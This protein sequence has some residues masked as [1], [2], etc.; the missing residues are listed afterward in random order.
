MNLRKITKIFKKDALDLLRSK[1]R[2]LAL[3]LFPM[4]M[5]F[6]FGFGFGGQISGVGVVVTAEKKTPSAN[7]VQQAMVSS[8]DKSDF[9]Q[10][11]TKNITKQ[12][13][14]HLVEEG[15]YD[16]MIYIPSD[17]SL[18]ASAPP[19]KIQVFV[20]PANSPQLRS[21]VMEGIKKVVGN[22]RGETS[23]VEE[24]GFYSNLEYM[25][26]L[27]PAVIVLTIFFAAGQGTGR[28]LAGEKEEGTLDRLAMTPTS[29]KEI[30]AGKTIYTVIVQLI[31]AA[32]IIAAITFFFGVVMNGSW[33]LV[34]LIVLLLTI[35]SVGIGLIL[36]AIS[37]DE[38]TYSELSMMTILPAMFVTGVFF[39]VASI[40]AWIRP[41]AYIYP[42]T[43][44]NNAIRQVML[45]GATLGEV[46]HNLIILI[47]FAIGLYLIGSW[48]FN[49]TARG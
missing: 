21:A 31:R 9:F 29:A 10:V 37:E 11:T 18:K 19:N 48:L 32:I 13:A 27:A 2:L 49:K 26:F 36:S 22:L 15:K 28:A 23:S 40:P 3:F 30:V 6:F 33:L 8:Q 20:S 43:Y 34:A 25:D 46:A 4:L 14:R 1:G 44:A 24:A 42:L 39:P 12:E 38:S 47:A 16:A 45:I 5:I 17:F 7:A 35:A 41:I